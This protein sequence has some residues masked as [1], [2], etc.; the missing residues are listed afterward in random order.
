[1]SWYEKLSKYFP[2]EEMKSKEHMELLLKEKADIYYKD[3]GQNHVIMFVETDDF[4]FVDYLFVSK[5]ARGQGLGKQLLQKLKD[6]NKPIIL[7]VEPVDYEDT[8]TVKRNRFYEREGFTHAQSVGYRKKSLATNQVNELEILY[9]SP[10]DESEHSIYEKMK[11]TYET[12]HTYKDKDL[13]GQSYDAV[14]QAVTF[15]HSVKERE[16]SPNG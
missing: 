2:I 11:H 14:D 3:E 9:W 4:V 13:Y 10:T 8:D 7:E 16:K 15:N 5:N 6:K 12:I 1:M